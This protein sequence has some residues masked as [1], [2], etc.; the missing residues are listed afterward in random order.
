[1]AAKYKLCRPHRSCAPCL[2]WSEPRTADCDSYRI[3]I[4]IYIHVY[5]NIYCCYVIFIHVYIL[6]TNARQNRFSGPRK[7]TLAPRKGL[8]YEMLFKYDTQSTIKLLSE[9]ERSL[10]IGIWHIINYSSWIGKTRKFNWNWNITHKMNSSA[11][12][13][14]EVISIGIEI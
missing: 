5:I 6:E 9:N 7:R 13:E 4:Y 11:G 14:Q 3:Y 12:V 1:M 2:G 10:D 8:E